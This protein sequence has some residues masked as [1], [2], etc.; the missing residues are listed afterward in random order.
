MSYV[1][2]AL[3]DRFE[4]LSID[5]KNEILSRNVR[6]ETLQDLIDILDKIASEG[7]TAGK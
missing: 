3:R 1:S 6:L 7:E 4:S 2:P 5:L